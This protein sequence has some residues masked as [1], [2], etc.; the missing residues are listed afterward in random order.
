MTRRN[1]TAAELDK[2]RELYATTDNAEIGALI[3]RTPNAVKRMAEINGMRKDDE[4]AGRW[5]EAESA[6][7]VRFYPSTP[8]REM[9]RLLG[10]SE[11]SIN[12]RVRRLGLKRAE[13]FKDTGRTG[14]P[15]DKRLAFFEVCSALLSRPMGASQPEIVEACRSINLSAKS[16]LFKA[17]KAGQLHMAGKHKHTRYFLTAEAAWAGTALI[18][19]EAVAMREAALRA[20]RKRESERDAALR[21]SRPPKIKP[22]KPPKPVRPPKPPKP[23]KVAKALP[24]TAKVTKPQRASGP[25]NIPGDWVPA[26]GFKYTVCPTPP[27]AIYTNTHSRY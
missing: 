16:F 19:A 13:G 10:R 7:L 18:E 8:L 17:A 11:N 22:E 24:K 3:G 6:E 14:A 26:P 1:W 2:V 20:K 12:Q 9:I 21:A 4:F 27:S 15:S 23:P 5:T 25:A